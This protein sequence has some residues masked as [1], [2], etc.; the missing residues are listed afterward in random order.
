MGLKE[1]NTNAAS[2]DR[3]C[4]NS[5]YLNKM[6][7]VFLLHSSFNLS[8]KYN[9]S[10]IWL[11]SKI[12]FN[13]LFRMTT[14]QRYSKSIYNYSRATKLLKTFFLA[15]HYVIYYH[16]WHLNKTTH[17]CMNYN[18]NITSKYSKYSEFTFMFLKTKYGIIMLLY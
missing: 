12:V 15:N 10:K 9:F 17:F 14:L 8:I 7:N 4:Q 2:C 3:L 16:R 13:F 18:I 11:I 5:G 6:L 1:N